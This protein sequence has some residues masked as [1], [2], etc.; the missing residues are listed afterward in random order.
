[1]YSAIT[2]QVEFELLPCLKYH[3]LRFYAY[4]PLGGGILT[5]KYK[6]DMES[7]NSIDYGRFNMSQKE[8]GGFDKVRGHLSSKVIQGH[9]LRFIV[10]VTGKLN[11]SMQSIKWAICSRNIIPMK[12]FQWLKQ[13]IDG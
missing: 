12:I 3:G 8:C 10:T 13:P 9:L 11:I 1:M 4:S 5:G 7:D 6:F 2:R